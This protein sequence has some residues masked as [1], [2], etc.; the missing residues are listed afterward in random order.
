MWLVTLASV[1]SFCLAVMSSP[2]LQ[3]KTMDV[4]AK[5]GFYTEKSP[6]T[7]LHEWCMQKKRPTPR[8][9]ITAVEE[10]EQI[11]KA[12][13][14]CCGRPCLGGIFVCSRCYQP[15]SD[16]M[17][18]GRG[19]GW[20]CLQV[21]LADP[22][23]RDKDVVAFL[24]AEHQCSS[25][26]ESGQRVAVTALHR[27]A[28]ERALHRV[29]PEMYRPLWHQL[30]EHVRRRKTQQAEDCVLFHMCAWCSRIDSRM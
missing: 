25:Q 11:T 17:V 27:V 29:L 10:G 14:Q 23:D 30:G 7:L 12:K 6:K 26:E 9:R 20:A 22:K 5:A 24:A 2:N 1:E 15:V 3:G 16:S 28:G 19:M 8:Y 18:R 13:V 4:G 21:V